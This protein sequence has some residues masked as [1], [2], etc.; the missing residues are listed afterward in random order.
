T[1]TAGIDEPMSQPVTQGYALESEETISDHYAALQAWNE[2][3]GNQGR[4]SAPSTAEGTPAPITPDLDAESPSPPL[5]PG[6]SDVWAE[7]QQEF[8]PYSQ[9]FSRIRQRR[10]NT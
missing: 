6:S 7:G 4:V 8:A 9:L 1:P 5:S 3:A 2:W 10:D